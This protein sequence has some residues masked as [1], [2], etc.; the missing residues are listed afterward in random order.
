MATLE[1][2]RHV[3]R[4]AE[5]D[6]GQVRWVPIFGRRPIDGLPQ[7]VWEN[8]QTWAEANL[9]ALEQ[10]TTHKKQLSTVL[11]AM[12]ALHNYAKWLEQEQIDWWHFPVREAERSL[13]RYRGALVGARD[14]GQLA[15]STA[16]SRMAAT[17][18]FYRWLAANHLLSPERPMWNE[19]QVGIRLTDPFGFEHTLQVNS[20]DLAIPNRKA[21]GSTLEDGLL[22]VTAD[23]AGSILAFAES[24]ASEELAL[25]LLLGFF[26]G[27]RLGT[28]ADLKVNTIEA[29]VPDPTLRGWFRLAVGPGATAPVHTK[30]A[31]TGQIFI[32]GSVLDTLRLYMFSV[33]RLKR[34]TLASDHHRGVVFLNRFGKPYL[35]QSVSDTSRAINVE[36]GRLRNKGVAAGVHARHEF[37]FHRS[38]CTFATELARVAVR[39]LPLGDAIDLVRE[40]LLHKDEATT[41]KYIKFAQK[42]IAMAEA[43]DD[44]TEAMMGL[45]S[46]KDRHSA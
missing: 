32:P 28:I 38:R 9:W 20:T 27:M 35:D 3:E 44:F 6:G 34:Q 12:T 40:S 7:I 11:S 22:P 15:P 45:A 13:N 18:R 42:T 8:G 4:R 16:S 19:R 24:E 43:A 29:A 37:H 25:M 2:I 5:V 14:A 41:L 30:F 36:M 23:A 1:L 33:R 46:R 21:P 39:Y 26:T 17:V 10:A 31:K